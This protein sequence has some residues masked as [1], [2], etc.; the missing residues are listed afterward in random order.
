MVCPIMSQ[1]LA[2]KSVF[3]LA[4]PTKKEGKF[5]PLN[6]PAPAEFPTVTTIPSKAKN[7]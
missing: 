6:S 5:Q 7:H 1:N 3:P 4:K 2:V